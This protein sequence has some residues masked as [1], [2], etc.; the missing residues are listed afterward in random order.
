MIVFSSQ[1]NAFAYSFEENNIGEENN[2]KGN[3]SSEQDCI[4]SFVN[5]N[6]YEA[7]LLCS[8]TA[9][10]D[11]SHDAQLLVGLM[12]IFGEGTEKNNDL[13]KFWLNKATLNGSEE[14]K[15]ILIDF[16]LMD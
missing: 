15:K 9:E 1:S 7:F 13:A 2:I 4:A 8:V 10:E 11:G 5:S 14:A 6:F 3:I 12:Y 16:K